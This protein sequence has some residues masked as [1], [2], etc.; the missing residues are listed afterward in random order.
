MGGM[1]AE[2]PHENPFASPEVFGEEYRRRALAFGRPGDVDAPI[3][4]EGVMSERDFL[5]SI[6]LVYRWGFWMGRLV[7]L[8]GAGVYVWLTFRLTAI[9]GV[10]LG[11]RPFLLRGLPLLL[12]VGAGSALLL[13]RQTA[14]FRKA[15]SKT[16][17]R[18]EVITMRIT[19]DV[20]EVSRPSAYTLLRWIS[21]TKYR[22][23]DDDLMIL[24]SAH[25][26]NHFNI[27]PRRFFAPPDWDRFV[28]LVAERLPR[29]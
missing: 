29:A 22:L 20:I 10:G 12:V 25:A 3:Y 1:P 9:W 4:A 2:S 15:W 27:F 24:W 5:R 11:W 17:L 19:H 16:A 26:G 6:K 7:L 14:R 28:T 13:T 23:Y 8:V 21:Y 18:D